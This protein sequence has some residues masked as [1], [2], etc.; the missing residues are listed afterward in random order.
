MVIVGNH[1]ADRHKNWNKTIKLSKGAFEHWNYLKVFDMDTGDLKFHVHNF[2]GVYQLSASG[3]HIVTY[4][5]SCS[6]AP[7]NDNGIFIIAN[8]ILCVWKLPTI[9]EDHSNIKEGISLKDL[10][11]VTKS[12]FL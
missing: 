1:G 10:D 4:T 11:E 5:S 12:K 8:S 2:Q 9:D 7:A 3:T 6:R